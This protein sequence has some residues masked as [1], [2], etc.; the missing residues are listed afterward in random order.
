MRSIAAEREEILRLITKMRGVKSTPPRRRNDHGSKRVARRREELDRLKKARHRLENR[1]V[2]DASEESSFFDLLQKLD[3][4]V[5][6]IEARLESGAGPATSAT[7]GPANPAAT[8]EEHALAGAVKEGFL[9]DIL[10]L[11][12]SNEM[13][14]VFTVEGDGS[15]VQLYYREGEVFHAESEDVRGESA[16]FVAMAMESGRFRFVETEELPEERTITSQ[17]Q[18]LVLEALRQIDEAR[19]QNG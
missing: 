5:S 7:A 13:T 17:T 16:F 1:L 4:R 6:A 12:S 11:V 18:F 19:A 15:L 2:G 8:T 10:Q 3:E 14:G 9:A